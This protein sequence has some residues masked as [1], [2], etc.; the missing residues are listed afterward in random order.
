MPRLTSLLAV[1][2]IA[3]CR[4]S[5]VA[6]TC[7]TPESAA[8]A[9]MLVTQVLLRRGPDMAPGLPDYSLSL[10][11][12]G[13]ALYVGSLTVPVPG[14]Y[15]GRLG[16]TDFQRIVSDLLA[17]GLTLDAEPREPAAHP[18]A[19][20]PVISISLQTADGRYSST[21]FCGRS[22]AESRL[23]GPIYSAIEQIRW[24]PGAKSLA[25]SPLN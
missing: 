11:A 16:P 17:R 19:P 23:A 20:Q 15:M 13:D 24:Y 22:D 1:A 25:L 2:A 7:P 5:Q 9:A 4:A 3:G 6:Q 8:S 12:S 14:Q 18:C 21:T 10:T